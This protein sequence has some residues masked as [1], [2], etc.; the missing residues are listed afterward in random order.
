MPKTFEGKKINNP[1]TEIPPPGY[2]TNG[3]DVITHG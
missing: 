1:F 3:P 2:E